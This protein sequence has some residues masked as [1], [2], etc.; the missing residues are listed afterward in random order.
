MRYEEIVRRRPRKVKAKPVPK[1]V[2]KLLGLG[3][4]EEAQPKK[5]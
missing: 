1:G 4:T 3:G 5:G 2:L